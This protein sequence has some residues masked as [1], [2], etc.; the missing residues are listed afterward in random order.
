[1]VKL[2]HLDH[3]AAVYQ[4]HQAFRVNL[5]ICVSPPHQFV[6]PAKQ[7]ITSNELKPGCKNIFYK[8]RSCLLAERKQK[9]PKRTGIVEH[10]L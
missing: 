8:P 10:G 3:L 4:A 2:Y 1:M 9:E 7:E 6:P 5:P